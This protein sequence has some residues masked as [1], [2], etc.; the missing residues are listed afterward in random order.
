[1]D[2]NEKLI[3]IGRQAKVLMELHLE[4]PKD[5]HSERILDELINVYEKLELDKDSTN[6]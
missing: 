2:Y 3:E 4:K 6:L 5:F 1:M